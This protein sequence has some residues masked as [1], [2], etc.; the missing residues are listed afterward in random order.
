MSHKTSSHGDLP[1]DQCDVELRK[2]LWFLWPTKSKRRQYLLS[3]F[4]RIF[5]EY[6][7]S[8]KFH[9]SA[10][11]VSITF[12]KHLARSLISLWSWKASL[13]D[14]EPANSQTSEESSS[15]TLPWRHKYNTLCR[16][17]VTECLIFEL[18][19]HVT[20]FLLASAAWLVVVWR[21]SL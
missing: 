1:D 8:F 21:D 18:Q 20:W 19:A 3:L 16:L 14:V 11:W 4:I 17:K 13:N 9:W 6:V 7:K 5:S 15:F 2:T 10:S 12:R